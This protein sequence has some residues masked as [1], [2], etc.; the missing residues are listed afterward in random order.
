MNLR[1]GDYVVQ[2]WGNDKTGQFPIHESGVLYRVRAIETY[3]DR[4]IVL[5]VPVDCTSGDRPEGYLFEDEELFA[6]VNI[7]VTGMP[8]GWEIVRIGVPELWEHYLHPTFGGVFE[9][10]DLHN[11]EYHSVVVIRKV[12]REGCHRP[13]PLPHQTSAIPLSPSPVS[14]SSV[15]EEDSNESVVETKEWVDVQEG[16]AEQNSDDLE[17]ITLYQYLINDD[18]DDSAGCWRMVI[19]T[20]EWIRSIDDKRCIQMHCVGKYSIPVRVKS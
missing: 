18:M 7:R 17:Q 15:S 11:F 8:A 1:N 4:N 12:V 19:A 9:R 6:K 3:M 10:H 16:L 13:D 14:P 2:V 5:A 20:P